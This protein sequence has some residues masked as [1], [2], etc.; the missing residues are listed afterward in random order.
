MCVLCQLFWVH[1]ALVK[2]ISLRAKEELN[3]RTDEIEQQLQLLLVERLHIAES[4]EQ[5]TT[6]INAHYYKEQGA[7]EQLNELLN[8]EK[9]LRKEVKANVRN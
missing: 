3:S 2:E 5:V 4:L 9:R 1:R 8:Y 7:Q 6:M